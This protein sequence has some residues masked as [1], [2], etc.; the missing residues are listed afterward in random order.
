MSDVTRV[1]K[2]DGSIDELTASDIASIK[3]IDGESDPSAL[4]EWGGE[5]LLIEF[6]GVADGRGFSL[7]HTVLRDKGYQ[8]SLYA[9]GYVNPDQLSYAFQTGFDG[10]LVSAER[11]SDYGAEAWQSVLEPLVSLSYASTSSPA[12]KSIWQIRHTGQSI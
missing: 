4:G 8:G 5:V 6:N 11:W 12:L 10:V 1:L 9:G 7:A 3:K 2:K